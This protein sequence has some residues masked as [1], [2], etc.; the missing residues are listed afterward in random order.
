MTDLA[1][2]AAGL[3][4]ME[5]QFFMQ[6]EWGS[7]VYMVGCDLIAKGLTYKRDGNIFLTDEGIALRRHLLD[8]LASDSAV[9]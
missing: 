6:K 3:T 2:L 9:G 1:K 7:W 8:Q 5:R 4:D